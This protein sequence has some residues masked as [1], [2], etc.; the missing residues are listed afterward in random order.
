MFIATKKCS[1]GLKSKFLS[2][3]KVALNSR[4]F[5][6]GGLAG[7]NVAIIE[8]YHSHNNSWTTKTPTLNVGRHHARA[9]SV[10][11]SWF[12]HLPGGCKGVI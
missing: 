9:V 10:P 7:S 11:A 8:E 5:A 12:D 2:L 1:A 4:V 6:V 3:I